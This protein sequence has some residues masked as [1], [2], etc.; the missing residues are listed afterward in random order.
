[1]K[2]ALDAAE[3]FATGIES[4]SQWNSKVREKLITAIQEGN[5]KSKYA[6][7]STIGQTSI[8][9]LIR[10]SVICLGAIH[11]V[12]NVQGV[13]AIHGSSFASKSISKG[14]RTVLGSAWRGDGV[15][16][17]FPSWLP[18][19]FTRAL[20]LGPLGPFFSEAELGSKLEEDVTE[21]DPAAHFLLD[22][23]SKALVLHPALMQAV[24]GANQNPKRLR[25]VVR[26]DE[27]LA[28]LVGSLASQDCLPLEGRQGKPAAIFNP[29][30]RSLQ[31]TVEEGQGHGP[32]KEVFSLLSEHLRSKFG[33]KS[34]GSELGIKL[35]GSK[36]KKTLT[37]GG[38]GSSS[39]L[40]SGNRIIF[41][42]V[43]GAQIGFIKFLLRANQQ[44]A[45][46]ERMDQLH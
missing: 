15:S 5:S 23:F 34:T 39:T 42:A 45:R 33:K 9:A 8:R 35:Q 30:F 20:N 2:P 14:I 21:D 44:I 38:S 26:R 16:G 7:S 28:D 41:V 40:Q 36:G 29:F 3:K 19:V 13:R 27:C 31:G 1:L 25:I 17:K 32:R 37:C 46:D 43:E 10:R 11:E 22:G 4:D 24:S 6:L 12:N 18:S